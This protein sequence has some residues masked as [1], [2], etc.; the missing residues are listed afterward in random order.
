MEIEECIRSLHNK[1]YSFMT[2]QVQLKGYPSKLFSLFTQEP[3]YVSDN[4]GENKKQE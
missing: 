1:K 2:V 4:M 3:L